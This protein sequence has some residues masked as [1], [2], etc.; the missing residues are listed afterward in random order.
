MQDLE[1]LHLFSL[2]FLQVL[3]LSMT[4]N[5][6]S[7]NEDLESWNRS[8]MSKLNLKQAKYVVSRGNLNCKDLDSLTLLMIFQTISEV[9]N[10]W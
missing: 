9:F 7:A 2:T 1:L 4:N 6:A 8:M 3:P 10:T 5:R